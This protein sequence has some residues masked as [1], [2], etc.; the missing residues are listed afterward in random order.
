[1]RI[2]VLCV[3]MEESCYC[4]VTSVPK[5]STSLATSPPSSDYPGT[6]GPRREVDNL[7]L[8]GP[9]WVQAFSPS[10]QKHT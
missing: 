2:G 3:R 1:M 9:E 10:M 5:S 6:I 8:G 7:T 4:V